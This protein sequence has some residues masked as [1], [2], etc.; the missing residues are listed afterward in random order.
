MK[1]DDINYQQWDE[2]EESDN[3]KTKINGGMVKWLNG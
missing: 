1:G 2:D 3:Y